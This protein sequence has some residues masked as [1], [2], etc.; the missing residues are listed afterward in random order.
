MSGHQGG[1]FLLLQA[2]INHNDLFNFVTFILELNL[3]GL[4]NS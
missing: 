2:L 3:L 1:N 4:P